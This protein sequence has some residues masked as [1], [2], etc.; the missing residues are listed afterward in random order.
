MLGKDLTNKLDGIHT[1]FT[2]D[3][4]DLDITRKNN[5]LHEIV[6]LKPDVLINCSAYT[7][8][9][10]C[11]VEQDKAFAVNA[12]GVKNL[13][14]ACKETGC[15]LYHISTDFV[16]DGKKKEPYRETDDTNPL[17]IYGKS[18]LAGENYIKNILTEYAIFRTSWLFGPYGNNFVSTILKISAEKDKLEVVNDQ[19]GC[20]TYTG[21]LAEIIITLLTRKT[22]GIYNV[23]NS[24]ICTW[25]DFARKIIELSGRIT[26]VLPI[27]SHQLTRPAIRPQFSALDCTKLAQ[28]IGIYP[29][30]WIYALKEY[31]NQ[32]LERI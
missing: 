20:P 5:V 7:N 14:L 2:R 11:E 12:E 23:C 31:L 27:S 15:V 16:F 22:R 17:S 1:L 28:E 10:K 24:G 6:H 13:A 4:E 21:D 26:K 25:Y 18:K 3:I 9:D 29:R 8:V 32:D 30:Q 19:A